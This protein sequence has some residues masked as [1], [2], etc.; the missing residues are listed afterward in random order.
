MLY[1]TLAASATLGFLFT[2]AL[3]ASWSSN[4]IS[5]R[6]AY[7]I[8]VSLFPAF[9]AFLVLKLTKMLVSWR[10]AVLIYV[11]LFALLV[12]IQAVGRKISIYS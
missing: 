7:G 12:I 10:G 4:P 1:L 3:Y 6:V 2:L 5:S 9:G 8:F 11:V